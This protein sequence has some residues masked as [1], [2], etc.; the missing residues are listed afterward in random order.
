MK[1]TI[2]LPDARRAARE[3]FTIVE[4]VFAMGIVGVMFVALYAGLAGGFAI[5]KLARE[6]TRATQILVEKMETVRLYTFDQ[7]VSNSFMPTNFSTPYYPITTTNQGTIYYG[8]VTV[9]D[10]PL[11]TSYAGDMKKVT[12]RL[13]WTTGALR[14]TRSISTYVSRYG[15]QNYIYY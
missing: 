13:D 14:R 5:I 1:L 8:K 4:V 7:I 15:M 6:N 3:A 10:T 9:S 2:R 11:A 12:V